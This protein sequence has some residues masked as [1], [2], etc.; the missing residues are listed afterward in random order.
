MMSV[1]VASARQKETDLEAEIG[2]D[3]GAKEISVT[4]KTA[5]PTA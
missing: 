4:T 5:T 3:K 2:L 1:A